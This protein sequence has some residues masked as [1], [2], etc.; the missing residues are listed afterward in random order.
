MKLVYTCSYQS[1]G[2][3]YVSST[4]L[5]RHVQ[6]FH[7]SEKKFQCGYCGKCLASQQNLK[8]H[9]YIHTGEKP[10]VCPVPGCLAS[11]RQ[12]THLSAHKKFEHK[13]LSSANSSQYFLTVNVITS[14]LHKVNLQSYSYESTEV[15]NLKPLPLISRPQETKLPSINYIN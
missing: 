2:K 4:I 11:F 5:K 15:S 12:G 1:C 7:S 6:A 3:A 13:G 10:Y 14:L 9:F 8:E